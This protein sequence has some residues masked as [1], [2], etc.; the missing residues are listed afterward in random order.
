MPR[1]A[2]A[3]PEEGTGRAAA[4]PI[5]RSP[6]TGRPRMT[7]VLPARHALGL[8]HGDVGVAHEPFGAGVRAGEGDA[9]AQQCGP[10]FSFIVVC[11]SAQATGWVAATAG[12]AAVRLTVVATTI[13]ASRAGMATAAK[14][15]LSA[16][17]KVQSYGT[18]VAQAPVPI[19]TR[20]PGFRFPAPLPMSF[21][22]VSQARRRGLPGQRQAANSLETNQPDTM[23]PHQNAQEPV[24]GSTV[25]ACTCPERA[26]R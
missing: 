23:L 10:Q 11:S 20:V 3:R 4:R 18:A 8:V 15:T 19:D 13:A 7:G 5:P 1:N 16:K 26:P 22:E 21:V 17:A 25:H 6:A 24:A 12:G 14:R 9:D 2:G